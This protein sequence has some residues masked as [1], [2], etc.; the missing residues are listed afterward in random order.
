MEHTIRGVEPARLQEWLRAISTTEPDEIDC[1]VVIGVIEQ[2]VE[3]AAAG[4][5]VRRLFPALSLHLD[6]CPDCR[7]WY[8]DLVDW[9]RHNG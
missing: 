7:V 9:T 4:G 6:H 2:A 5:D 3:A 1:D 8:D